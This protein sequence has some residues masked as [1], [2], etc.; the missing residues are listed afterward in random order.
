MSAESFPRSL[1]ISIGG[2]I[3]VVLLIFFRAVLAPSNSIELSNAIRVDIVGL[4]QKAQQLPDAPP[5]EKPAPAKA[6][7]LPPKVEE[8]KPEKTHAPEVPNSKAKQKEA[9]KAQ[10]RALEKLKAMEA[11]EKLKQDVAKEKAAARTAPVAGNIQSAGNSLTGLA[12]RDYEAYLEELKTKVLAAWNIPQWLA[13]Q[14]LKA[15]VLVLIDDRG[16]VVKKVF[17]KSSGNPVFDAKVTEAIDGSAPWPPPPQRLRGVLSSSG[18]V[19]KFP[20]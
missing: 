14:D 3:A 8:A 19:F 5:V 20:Q 16:F 9:E 12:R 17:Q 7:N 2:H 1:I 18:I 10:K 13:E 6:P 15:E 11:L 4:P